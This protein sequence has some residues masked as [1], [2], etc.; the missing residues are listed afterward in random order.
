[1]DS[2]GSLLWQNP[3]TCKILLI[4]II[5]VPD[6]ALDA[7]NPNTH[8]KAYIDWIKFVTSGKIQQKSEVWK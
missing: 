5:T 8:V 3:A 6:C 4:G 2:G 7:L 1:M